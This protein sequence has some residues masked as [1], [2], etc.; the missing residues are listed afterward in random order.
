MNI[1][2]NPDV[3]ALIRQVSDL[4]K[5]VKKKDEEC[6][7]VWES[8]QPHHRESARNLIHYLVLRG[9]DL[10]DLQEGLS[11]LSV[12]SL[13]HSEGY[14]LKNL[15]NILT[16][17]KLIDGQTPAPE[18]I[19]FDTP[20]NF[21]KGREQLHRN[22]EALFGETAP[23]GNLSKIM[24]TMPIEA[25]DDYRLIRSML[26][27]GMNIARIN[28]GHDGPETWRRMIENIRRGEKE[29]GASCLIY[30]DLGGP[31]LRT[32]AIDPA[33]KI[34]D[35]KGGHINLYPGNQ[36]KVYRY[37]PDPF[38]VPLA[39][40]TAENEETVGPAAISTTL[41]QIVDDVRVG[42]PIFFDD[43]QI[44]GVISTVNRDAFLVDINQ[45]GIKGT[46]LRSDKGINLP[47]TKLNLPS[48]TE[49]DYANL[50][51]IAQYADIVGYSFVRRPPD[52]EALQT[53]LA[54]L[55]RPDMGIV[56]KIETKSSFENLPMLLLTAMRSPKVGIMIARGDLAVEVG[57]ERIAEV[58][59]EIL[60][61]C[62]AAHIPGIWATQV[63]EKLAK[64]GLATRA[65]ITD[66][67]M[68]A[69]AECVMLNKGPYIDNA[70]AT[71]HDIIYRMEKHQFKRKNNLRPLS[72]ASRFLKSRTATPA[73]P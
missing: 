10:R 18:D 5:I 36:V 59:E 53:E 1:H 55:G 41:P 67:A 21:R 63:L 28:T 42:H 29:T 15:Q 69:R 9:Y 44:S 35:R 47:D 73:E 65:E 2:T 33:H 19:A 4:L 45:A 34:R 31:K 11:M 39:W 6:R 51:F 17:L 48:L 23:G 26:L 43:G 68:S 64:K 61:L 58:Q 14:T 30:M 72:V 12:S 60:W 8:V 46:K 56:L 49:E 25:A 27:A 71:L 22:A 24:V 50:P 62:E 7:P 16:I 13:G 38:P 54:R 66:A 57:F 37:M 52:V 3:K 40:T 70:V 32:L 20:F